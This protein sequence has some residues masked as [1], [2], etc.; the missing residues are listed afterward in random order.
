MEF[1]RRFLGSP[2][3]EAPADADVDEWEWWAW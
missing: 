1:L 3:E 2:A